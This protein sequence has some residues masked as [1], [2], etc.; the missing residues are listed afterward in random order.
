VRDGVR[1]IDAFRAWCTRA[2]SLAA[3]ADGFSTCETHAIIDLREPAGT[4]ELYYDRGTGELTAVIDHRRSPSVC[5]AGTKPTG[6]MARSGVG[7]SCK[8]FP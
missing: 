7:V 1:S 5:A 8:E 6:C 4:R 2:G 3:L